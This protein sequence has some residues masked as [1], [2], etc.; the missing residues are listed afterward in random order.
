MCADDMAGLV[1]QLLYGLST[2]NRDI[3]AETETV[4]VKVP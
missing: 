4:V 2:I 1:E 3:W